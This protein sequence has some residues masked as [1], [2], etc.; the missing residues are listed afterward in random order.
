MAEAHSNH[1]TQQNSG[2]QDFCGKASARLENAKDHFRKKHPRLPWEPCKVACYGVPDSNFP[3]YCGFCGLED[4]EWS[5]EERHKHISAHFKNDECD[6]LQWQDKIK[7]NECENGQLDDDN[8]DDDDDDDDDGTDDMDDIDHD[9]VNHDGP[10]DRRHDNSPGQEPRQ[11][12]NPRPESRGGKQR[13]LVNSQ[14]YEVSEVNATM[15]AFK[16]RSN[17]NDD[18]PWVCPFA[19][20]PQSKFHFLRV[21]VDRDHIKSAHSD[22]HA[23]KGTTKMN[24]SSCKTDSTPPQHRSTFP[25]RNTRYTGSAGKIP[26]G[27]QSCIQGPTSYGKITSMQISSQHLLGRGGFGV[28]DKVKD[29]LTGLFFARK[30]FLKTKE[31]EQSFENEM[32]ALRIL[33]QHRSEHVVNLVGYS[34]QLQSS[35]IFLSPVADMN[36]SQY[37]NTSIP[38]DSIVQSMMRQLG[39]LA[40]ALEYLHSGFHMRHRDIKPQNILVCNPGDAAP[41]R[42]LFSDFGLSKIQ[43]AQPEIEDDENLQIGTKTYQPPE[44]YTPGSTLSKS[45]DIWS[46]GCVFAEVLSFVI[47]GNASE[48]RDY[49]QKHFRH[50]RS[51]WGNIPETQGWLEILRERSGSIYDSKINLIKSMLNPDQSLRPTPSEILSVFPS[52]SC[53]L[54]TLDEFREQKEE[55]D[56]NAAHFESIKLQRRAKRHVSGRNARKQMRSLARP[57]PNPHHYLKP[58]GLQRKGVFAN[59]VVGQHSN[60]VAKEGEKQ[61]QAEKPQCRM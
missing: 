46:L 37:L 50:N 14:K 55:V 11:Q 45:W 32:K 34:S 26:P 44:I 28:V 13:R 16:S 29:N 20:N 7:H 30:T 59:F 22:L 9:N 3:R 8:D 54:S 18:P 12:R 35:S 15:D 6:M 25:S 60:E 40:N 53:C 47:I 49:R 2:A 48:F 51:F 5:W 4:L 23:T 31:A 1:L 52:A 10:E 36:L 24:Q 19:Q 56:A 38:T 41:G 43:K 57:S 27:E 21:W 39:C 58:G 61:R 33:S 17:I 42:W